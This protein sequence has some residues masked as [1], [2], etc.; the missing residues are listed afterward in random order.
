[1][2][3]VTPGSEHF[4]ERGIAA[5]LAAGLFPLF[6]LEGQRPVENLAGPARKLAHLALLL[7]AGDQLIT[8]G[9]RANPHLWG[10][11]LS[12]VGD[13]NEVRH[14]RHCVFKQHIEPKKT[15]A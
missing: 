13:D 6:I 15:P 14:G 5:L 3:I 2:R 10:M 1:L 11:I 12:A 8:E 7:G 9:L 4:T